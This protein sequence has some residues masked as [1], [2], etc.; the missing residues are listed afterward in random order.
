MT[1]QIENILA[2]I[3]AIRAKLPELR[4]LFWLKIDRYNE[5]DQQRGVVFDERFEQQRDKLFRVIDSFTAFIEKSF[6]PTAE[7]IAREKA[8]QKL[9]A[10]FPGFED[11]NEE[12]KKALL[13]KEVKKISTSQNEL[14]NSALGFNKRSIKEEL[15]NLTIL[16]GNHFSE[17]FL[18][19]Y[20][21][22]DPKPSTHHAQKFIVRNYLLEQ[23]YDEALIRSIKKDHK[24]KSSPKILRVV[25]PD[26]TIIE[27]QKAALTFVKT[28]EKI[29]TKN[30]EQ[31]KIESIIRSDNQFDVIAQITQI[32]NF[33]INT[34]S[35]TIEKKRYLDLISQQL[36]LNLK[37]EISETQQD[38]QN[39]LG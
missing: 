34:H 13:D 6:A 7:E 3:K 25:F 31:L 8:L 33:Y 14:P 11:W 28:I 5:A 35:S 20:K 24:P 9:R 22:L 10:E 19:F 4:D 18:E 15:Q 26:G 30:V 17:E 1:E 23:G 29:G 2:E 16:N 39:H 27:E 38:V 37:V 21:H 12:A 32:G 36:N